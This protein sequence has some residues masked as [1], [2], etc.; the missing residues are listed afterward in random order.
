M[1]ETIS[2]LDG[3]AALAY[4]ALQAGRLDAAGVV[5]L[6]GAAIT[7]FEDLVESE[8]DAWTSVV[9]TILGANKMLLVPTPVALM[10]EHAKRAH[11]RAVLMNLTLPDTIVGPEWDAAVLAAL[12]SAHFI[13]PTE[14]AKVQRRGDQ[15][16][17]LSEGVPYLPR[18]F[19]EGDPVLMAF[20]PIDKE[21]DETPPS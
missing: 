15:Y 3:L 4:L 13:V 2:P 17:T 1:I 9:A 19:K 20:I 7:P 14:V 18:K 5:D 6:E 21:P 12:D 8:R 16:L 10:A 11:D